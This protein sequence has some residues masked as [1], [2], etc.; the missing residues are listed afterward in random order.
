M[1]NVQKL[2]GL[3]TG[4]IK[5]PSLQQSPKGPRSDLLPS[6]YQ[7]LGT[8]NEQVRKTSKLYIN[9]YDVRFERIRSGMNN[10]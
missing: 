8:P 2:I 7:G 9:N 3:D 4:D 5:V 10:G 6:P 1:E